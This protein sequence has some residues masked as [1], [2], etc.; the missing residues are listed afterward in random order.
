M[1]AKGM[2][3]RN[4]PIV[5][6]ADQG[7]RE[8]PIIVPSHYAIRTVGYEDPHS[9]QMWWFNLRVEQ[10]HYIEEIGLYFKL[11]RLENIDIDPIK[12]SV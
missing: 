5:P 10:L 6:D 7:T 8:N 3:V 1:E 2:T 12:G 4:M 11:D 9:G